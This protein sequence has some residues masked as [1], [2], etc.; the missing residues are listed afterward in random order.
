MY[1]CHCAALGTE[2]LGWCWGNAGATLGRCW[3]DAGVTSERCWTLLVLR[4]RELLGWDADAEAILGWPWCTAK[5][6][7]STL[8]MTKVQ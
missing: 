1:C 6:L 4:P 3:V 8:M 5:I 7:G 2:S